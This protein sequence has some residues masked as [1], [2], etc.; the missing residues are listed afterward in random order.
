VKTTYWAATEQARIAA[1][2]SFAA[3]SANS[4]DVIGST[5]EAAVESASWIPF[6]VLVSAMMRFGGV[7]WTQ[8]KVQERSSSQ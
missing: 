2:K 8:A 4:D 7:I 5:I 1:L 6:T 3:W